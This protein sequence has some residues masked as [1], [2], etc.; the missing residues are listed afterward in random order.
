MQ[1]NETLS[2]VLKKSFTWES[3]N[4]ASWYLN[5][6]LLSM[7]SEDDGN[8]E[9]KRSFLVTVSSS[10]NQDSS[11]CLRSESFPVKDYYNT[12]C[13]DSSDDGNIIQLQVSLIN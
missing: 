4:K 2:E 12:S 7:V 1:Y 9:E 3:K 10:E 6:K 5:A 13:L 8:E 11:T